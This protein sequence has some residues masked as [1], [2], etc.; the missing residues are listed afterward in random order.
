MPFTAAPAGYCGHD[1]RCRDGP[2]WQPRDPS[3]RCSKGILI[4]RAL[5]DRLLLRFDAERSHALARWTLRGLAMIPGLTWLLNTL[6]RP[7]GEQLRVNALG[8]E[9]PSPLGLAAGVDKDASWFKPL[10]A[11]GFGFV[12]VGTVT[13]QAQAGNTQTKRRVTRLPADRGL[14]N[15]MGFPNPGAA[16]FAAR[17]ARRRT[18]RIVGVNIGKT[19]AVPD[20][21]TM[22]DYREAVR[23][24][25]P[26]ADFLVIN[27]SSPNTPGLLAWQDTDRLRILLR[28]V[29][30]ELSHA[31]SKVPVLIKIG[32][33]LDQRELMDIA[34]L[35][36]EA[37][38]DGIV[39]VNTSKDFA[40]A[41]NSQ[42]VIAQASH[43]G[44]ISGRP[45]KKRALEVLETLSE[46]TEGSL[47]L[48]SVGGIETPEDAWDRL[49]AGASLVQAHTA[50]VYEG[51]LWASRMNKGLTE[52]LARSPWEE[53]HDVIGAGR[54]LSKQD[55]RTGN[56]A[57][58]M[59]SVAAAFRV[60]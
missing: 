19:K 55:P 8:L 21:E 5:F 12:E 3:T 24:L 29:R 2:A 26:V 35:A 39:A 59:R 47:V 22:A 51:P 1:E 20:A 28:E 58:S 36:R 54:T 50:F 37:D 40:L 45:L 48:I 43:E 60:H 18:D 11:L 38:L 56:P 57:P 17:L 30:R 6:L 53:I 44:G 41:A 10:G 16:V 31:G 23:Q 13:A 7:R 33:D 15:E 52:L 34:D 42:D 4:Y 49:L 46:R 32:S 27:V 25:A 14:L 9:F